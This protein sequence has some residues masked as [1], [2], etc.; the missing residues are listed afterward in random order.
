MIEMIT[1]LVNRRFIY[2]QDGN[3]FTPLK[4]ERCQ[5]NKNVN[6]GKTHTKFKINKITT[7]V[8]YI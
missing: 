2:G 4:E 8:N 1:I 6:C 5:M 3:N 7:T